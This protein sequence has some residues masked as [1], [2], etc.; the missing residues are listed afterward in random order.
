MFLYRGIPFP[1]NGTNT[2]VSAVIEINNHRLNF[3][4]FLRPTLPIVDADYN[5]CSKYLP[6]SDFII[7]SVTKEIKDAKEAKEAEKLS[8]LTERTEKTERT[9]RTERAERTDRTER[10]EKTDK[11]YNATFSSMNHF[12]KPNGKV[13]N[14]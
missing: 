10:T 13:N 9:E 2:N 7:N 1:P 3:F 6:N 11:F 12:T 5:N 14:F 4:R 8:E